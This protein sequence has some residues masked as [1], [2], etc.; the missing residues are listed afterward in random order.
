MLN[1][2]KTPV[3]VK[4]LYDIGPLSLDLKITICGVLFKVDKGRYGY[5]AQGCS[6]HSYDVNQIETKLKTKILS[7]PV[8]A[9]TVKGYTGSG[10]FPEFDTLENLRAFINKITELIVNPEA[11]LQ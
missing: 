11:T 6:A 5:Y 1:L 2:G 8:V 4:K 7:L 9:R 10:M 3:K